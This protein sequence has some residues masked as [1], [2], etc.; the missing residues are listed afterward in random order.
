MRDLKRTLSYLR[1]EL[2]QVNQWI[3]VLEAIATE[4]YED[5]LQRAAARAAASESTAMRLHP[6][7]R[8]DPDI[9]LW[10]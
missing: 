9:H 1:N 10:L 2:A 3:A 7:A 5:R 8:P 4:Q 6:P